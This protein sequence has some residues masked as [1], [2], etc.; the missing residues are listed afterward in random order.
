MLLCFINAWVQHTHSGLSLLNTT[1]QSFQ[2]ARREKKSTKKAPHQLLSSLQLSRAGGAGKQPGR[3]RGK[4]RPSHS[5]C[6]H[7][8]AAPESQHS[9]L[10]TGTAVGT[11]LSLK[12]TSAMQHSTKIIIYLVLKITGC[13]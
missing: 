6:L 7:T 4:A 13:L 1:F 3:G 10:V 8:G 5:S 12:H 2:L 11:S 9:S